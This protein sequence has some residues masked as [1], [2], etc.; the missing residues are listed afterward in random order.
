MTFGELVDDYRSKL[1]L[2]RFKGEGVAD[3][4]YSDYNS[5]HNRLKDEFLNIRLISFSHIKHWEPLSRKLKEASRRYE[6]HLRIL[7]NYAVR[8]RIYQI[9]TNDRKTFCPEITEA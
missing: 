3:R 7:F 1:D 5:R 2:D 6:N 4:T 8:K 9:V